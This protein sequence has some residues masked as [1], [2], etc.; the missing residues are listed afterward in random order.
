[1]K[2]ALIS[3]KRALVNMKRLAPIYLLDFFVIYI[4]FYFIKT[5]SY[6]L[7]KFKLWGIVPVMFFFLWIIKS[8]KDE[9]GKVKTRKEK[10]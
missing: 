5:I 2:E 6:A 9:Y 3:L 4:C 1:M 10:T 8:F 7:F